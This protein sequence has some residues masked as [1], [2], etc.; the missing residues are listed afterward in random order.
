MSLCIGLDTPSIVEFPLPRLDHLELVVV[1][2]LSGLL[3][4]VGDRLLHLV[5]LLVEG[6]LLPQCIFEVG[7]L[8][9]FKFG[10]I[11]V[12]VGKFRLA[13]ND[14]LLSY[15]VEKLQMRVVS[16]PVATLKG[17]SRGESHLYI[18]SH[19]D[20]GMG[21]F[22][23]PTL[24]PENTGQVQEVDWLVEEQNVSRLQ[25]RRSKCETRTPAARKSSVWAHDALF[26][27]SEAGEDLSGTDGGRR[28]VDFV[29]IG[30]GFCMQRDRLLL[31]VSVFRGCADSARGRS[32]LVRYHSSHDLRGSSLLRGAFI[33]IL[34]CQKVLSCLS[35]PCA[36]SLA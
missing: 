16:N 28:G 7:A 32:T 11:A 27:E 19:D 31:P 8:R 10:Q 33:A 20:D 14:E 5:A 29:E 30:E 13:Q 1:A 15:R 17:G 23:D 18:V 6:F 36:T 21:A 12:K 26:A 25:E 9:R 35:T 22:V 34:C 24:E 2:R 4:I 3:G